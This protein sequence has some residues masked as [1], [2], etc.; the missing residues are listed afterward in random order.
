MQRVAIVGLGPIGA[1]LSAALSADG[2]AVIGVERDEARRAALDSTGLTVTGFGAPPLRFEAVVADVAELGALAPDVVVVATKAAGQEPLLGLLREAHQA[3]RRYVFAQN[4]IDNEVKA[5]GYLGQANVAR[6]VLNFGAQVVGPSEV[7]CGE[8]LGANLIGSRDE[9]EPA[10]VQ[11]VAERLTR[12]GLTTEHTDEIR[13]RN[14]EKVVLNATVNGICALT[15]QTLSEL[16]HCGAT[17]DYLRRFIAEVVTVA[18]ADGCR[19]DEDIVEETVRRIQRAGD[20]KPSM[21]QDLEA[22]RP[23]EIAYLNGRISAIGKRLGV[24]TPHNDT[25]ALLVRGVEMH[26]GICAGCDAGGDKVCRRCPLAF[27]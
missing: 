18:E 11:E 10:W 6:L 21:A 8:L 27:E 20:H 22:G 4:G 16:A 13:C 7:A 2:V 17:R 23:T 1:V 12:G 3:G 26:R 25:I 19:F 15:G 9:G 5:A 14:W 24:A